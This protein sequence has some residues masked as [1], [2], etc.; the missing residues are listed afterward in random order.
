MKQEDA[1]DKIMST[2]MDEAVIQRIGMLAK[3]LGTS[4]KAVL[5]NAIRHYAEKME[6]EFKMD[7]LEHTCGSWYRD[8]SAADTVHSIKDAMRESQERYKR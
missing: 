6:A 7:I 1:V 3:K 2:R 4:K 8:E 5:E